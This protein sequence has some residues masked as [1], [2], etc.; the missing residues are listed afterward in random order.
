MSEYHSTNPL[1]IVIAGPTAVGKTRFAIDLAQK[2][3]TEILSADSRQFYQELNIGTAKPSPEELGLVPHHFVGQLS[4]HDYYNISRYEQEALVLL[5]NLFRRNSVA[6]VVGGS[7]LYIDS[8]CRGVDEFPDPDPE[9][10]SYLKGILTDEGIGKLQELVRLHDPDYYSS[11]DIANPNR[12]LRAL[13]VSMSTGIPYSEQRL[14]QPRKR[15]FNI[16]KIGLDLP[17]AELFNRI[18]QRVDQMM[19]NGLLEE[20]RELIPFK[21]LN[22]L[23]TVGYKEL[24]EYFNEDISLELAVENIKTHTRRYAKRQLTW[25][26]KDK[27]YTWF[28]PDQLEMVLEYIGAN[29]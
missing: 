24:F 10:R 15:K 3:G 25:F 16:I 17:R 1:L 20:V 12:L 18:N 14:N 9:L 2:L 5:D 4:I 13:E 22:A 29:N 6:L 26:R 8:V 19:K 27:E 11:V 7:G 28:A 21:H 23:N